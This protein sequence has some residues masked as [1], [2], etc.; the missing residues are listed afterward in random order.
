MGTVVEEF[1]EKNWIDAKIRKGKRGGAF[2]S[3]PSPNLHPHVFTNFQGSPRD[4]MTEAHELG[5][6][7]HGMLSRGQHFLDYDTPLTTAETASVFGEMLVFESL[8]NKASSD[9]ERLSLL[10]QKIED[11]IAAVFRQ[12][13]MYKFEARAHYYFR[14]HGRISTKQLN[15]WWNEEQQAIFGES[16]VLRPEHGCWWMYV[17]HI[18]HTPFYVYSYSFGELL[19]LSL[20]AKYKAGETDFEAKYVKLLSAGGSKSPNELLSA[21]FGVNLSD[22]NFWKEGLTVFESFLKEAEELAKKLGY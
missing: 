21:G 20:Y 11:I 17:P 12:I 9:E 15:V 16:L 13:A 5:H 6:G 14:E 22:E 8:K 1:Y 2:C 19:T 7:A 3:S 10:A 4:I 18:Y